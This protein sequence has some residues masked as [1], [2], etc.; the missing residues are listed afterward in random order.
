M[1]ALLC[2]SALSMILFL[3]AC[4][5]TAHYQAKV[6]SW[7]GQDVASLVQAWGQPDDKQTVHG[8][9]IMYVYARLHRVPVAYGDYQKSY[10]ATNA[11]TPANEYHSDIYI[12]CSTYFEI[13]PSNKIIA[14]DFRGDECTSK[15]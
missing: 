5:T 7:E 4:A 6:R 3:D 10:Y 1:K 11:R 12:K 14:T 2:L 15:D 9:N 8:H 13:S